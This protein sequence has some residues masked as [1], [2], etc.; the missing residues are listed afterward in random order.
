[1][2]TVELAWFQFDLPDHATT[3][4]V[5]ASPNPLFPDARV[6]TQ[7]RIDL[8]RFD[9]RVG[10]S[11]TRDLTDLSRQAFDAGADTNRFERNSIPG[12]GYGDYDQDR[13]RIDWWFSLHGLTLMLGLQA[14]GFPRT[15]PS[16]AERREHMAIIDSVRRVEH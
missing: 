16:E 15:L 2:Y 7:W 5:T 11:A 13:T 6:T 10:L 3:E 14:K 4:A 1:M 9:M 12:L 8:E